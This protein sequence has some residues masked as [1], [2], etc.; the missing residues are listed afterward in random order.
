[1]LTIGG[2]IFTN[3]FLRF[4]MLSYTYVFFPTSRASEFNLLFKNEYYFTVI[5]YF[6]CLVRTL[7]AFYK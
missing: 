3:I 6:I 4:L 5:T 2:S 1:M 7:A